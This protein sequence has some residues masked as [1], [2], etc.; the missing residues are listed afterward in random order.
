[1]KLLTYLSALCCASTALA[2]SRNVFNKPKPRIE[3]RTAGQPFKHP[4]IQKR[5][6]RFLTDKTE[7]KYASPMFEP[8][9]QLE[10]RSRSMAPEYL[11]SHS[12][13]ANLTLGSYPYLMTPMRRE[14][15]FSGTNIWHLFKN[16]IANNF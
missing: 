13:S 16:P 10:Q 15:S 14:S 1:M 11:K 2:A 5:A 9:A 4:E 6:S 7:G 12:T 8:Q 3:K